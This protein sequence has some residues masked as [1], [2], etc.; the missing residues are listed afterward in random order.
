MAKELWRGRRL[1]VHWPRRLAVE[2]QSGCRWPSTTLRRNRR[3]PP[4]FPKSSS[5]IK[6]PQCACVET[7]H[8][9]LFSPSALHVQPHLQSCFCPTLG[10]ELNVCEESSFL[11]GALYLSLNNFDFSFK[12]APSF[13]FMS[14]L[15][16][17]MMILDIFRITF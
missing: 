15:L 4:T 14:K 13:V 7:K 9:R 5:S 12:R 11:N 6:R 16:T 2:L 8:K 17:K 3:S 1:Q 10:F